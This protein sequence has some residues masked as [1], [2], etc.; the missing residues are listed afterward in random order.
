MLNGK[1]C[2]ILFHIV[3]GLFHLRMF[4]KDLIFFSM[5]RMKLSIFSVGC[6]TWVM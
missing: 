5:F 6:S 3:V 1:H 2:N 4:G